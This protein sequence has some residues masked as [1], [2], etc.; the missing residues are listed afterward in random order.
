MTEDQAALVKVVGRHFDSHAIASQSLDAVFLHLTGS[1]SHD[2]VASVELNAIARGR[3]TRL[4][5]QMSAVGDPGFN[6][7]LKLV[8]LWICAF[9]SSAD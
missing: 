2:F 7:I 8:A 3:A 4:R 6:A 1:V 5:Q 9:D